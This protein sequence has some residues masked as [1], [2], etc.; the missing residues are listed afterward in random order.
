MTNF[1][2]V[3]VDINPPKRLLGIKRVKVADP[4]AKGEVAMLIR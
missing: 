1:G 2:A 4:E 3:V